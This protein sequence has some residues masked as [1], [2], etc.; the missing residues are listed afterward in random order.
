[1]KKKINIDP[2]VIYVG[3]ASILVVVLIFVSVKFYNSFVQ[4]QD[5][6]PTPTAT[7]QTEGNQTKPD[8]IE[9]TSQ[10]KVDVVDYTVYNLSEVDFKFVIARV[11]VKAS[12]AINMDLSG[13]KT[14]EGISLNQV[15]SYISKLEDKALFLGK[16]NVWYEIVSSENSTISSIFIPLKDKKSDSVSV[17]LNFGNNKDL[18]FDLSNATGKKASLEYQSDDVITDGKTYQMK[19]SNAY[20]ITGETITRKYPSGTTE[21]YIVGSTSEMHA[22]KVEAVSLWGEK[23]I[24]ESAYY[25]VTETGETFEAF[26]GQF[27][28]EKSENLIGKTI[29][30]T[31]SGVLFFETLNP[32]QSPIKYK[33]VLKLKIQGQ[34][35]Y[36]VI[37]VDM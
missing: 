17:S 19:V 16:Q 13:F 30:N 34:D 28:T 4:S 33:G 31:G 14:S 36:I 32:N 3:L 12:T 24:I 1:M 15:D 6:E 10:V 5:V 25:T 18:V 7:I 29:T 27:S 23:V 8:Q 37:N 11:R 35:N 9:D 2:K 21:E 22:F 20:K 26:N